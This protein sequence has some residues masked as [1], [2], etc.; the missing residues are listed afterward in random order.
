M[1]TIL[2]IGEPGTGKSTAIENLDPKTTVVITP[3]N[4]DLPFLG[5]DTNF[6]TEKQNRFLVSLIKTKKAEGST[7]AVLGLGDVI[8]QVNKA[9]PH[10]RTLIIEDFTHYMSKKAMDDGYIK[11][12]DK[13]TDLA[14]QSFQE[15][16]EMITGGSLRKDLD[17]VLIGHVNAVSDAMGNMEIG[18]QTPGKLMDNLLKVL[19]HPH[20]GHYPFGSSVIKGSAQMR[21]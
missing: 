15:V 20:T 12:Y 4:K 10:V 6:S 21:Q 2:V 3:N 18:M 7:P 1:S 11:G 13:W 9:A 8:R 16:I 14:V 17:V 5:G 19:A